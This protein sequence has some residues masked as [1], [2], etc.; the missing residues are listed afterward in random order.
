MEMFIKFS[1][2]DIENMNHHLNIDKLNELFEYGRDFEKRVNRILSYAEMNKCSVLY[3]AEQSYIQ[4]IIDSSAFYY[5]S[6]FNKDFPTVLETVQCY[7]KDAPSKIENFISFY[8]ENNLKL[9]F[10]IVRGAYLNEETKL[11][12][13]LGYQ[14]LNWETIEET[15]NA[16]NNVARRLV[17]EYKCGDKVIF[18]T[19]E[20]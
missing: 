17:T 1:K 16:Y 8:R 10:K 14:R 15:H 20:R 11:S 13:K 6:L 9:G 7:M 19:Y 12:E 18:N 3:D 4:N 5:A 2:E